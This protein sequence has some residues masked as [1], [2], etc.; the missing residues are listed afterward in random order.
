MSL[1]NTAKLFFEKVGLYE[2]DRRRLAKLLTP[3]FIFHCLFAILAAAAL[4]VVLE[5]IGRDTL[6]EAVIALLYLL[7]VGWSA[8]RWGQAAGIFSAIASALCFD[9]FFIPP[10]H[11][12]TVARLEGWLVLAIFLI[13]AI[14]VVGRI[15]SGL[16]KAQENERDALFMYELSAA[17]A[18][19]NTQE[20]V[21]RALGAYLQQIF[22][23]ELVEVSIQ[24]DTQLEH[25]IIK[26]PAG[27]AEEKHPDLVLPILPAPGMLNEI[28]IWRGDGWLPPQDSRLLKNFSTQALLSLERGRLYEAEV[29]RNSKRNDD[30]NGNGH[31]NKIGLVSN[32][33]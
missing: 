4:T 2:A 32:R 33:N 6:G 10:F 8:A 20:S 7:P 9:Y 28:R 16:T 22:Q 27:V 11:S 15:Q 31:M 29:L 25:M 12:F 21:A 19:Q 5:L 14:V 17:L 18:G 24:P 23:A 30:G 26:T 1:L 3:D 13:V